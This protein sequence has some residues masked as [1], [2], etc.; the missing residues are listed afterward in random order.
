MRLLPLCGEFI[1]RTFLASGLINEP[2]FFQVENWRMSVICL[3]AMKTKLKWNLYGF[4]SAD[5]NVG[6]KKHSL[7]RP[8]YE[9]EYACRCWLKHILSFDLGREETPMTGLSH[10]LDFFKHTVLF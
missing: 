8:F 1:C 6:D 3:R 4:D 5:Y 7:P 10:V 2:T 9:V